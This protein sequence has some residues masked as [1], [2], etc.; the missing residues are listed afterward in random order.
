MRKDVDLMILIKEHRYKVNPRDVICFQSML[1]KAIQSMA[2]RGYTWATREPHVGATWVTRERFVC[3][4]WV[5]R[6]ATWYC[7]FI[8]SNYYAKQNNIN[9]IWSSFGVCFRK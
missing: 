8:Y 4:T 3:P 9:D 7:L 5:T 1:R 2:P 6:G